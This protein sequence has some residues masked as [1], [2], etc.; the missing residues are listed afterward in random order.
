MSVHSTIARAK[1]NLDAMFRA[2][3]A[4]SV[5]ASGDD[6]LSMAFAVS[7]RLR[8]FGLST[9]VECSRSTAGHFGASRTRY[10]YAT[11]GRNDWCIRVSNHA[12]PVYAS[13]WYGDPCLDLRLPTLATTARRVVD[14]FLINHVFGA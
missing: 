2:M 10:V 11:D 14:K 5:E 8:Q 12:R 3:P 6:I 7:S 4:W 1:P 13:E 9:T